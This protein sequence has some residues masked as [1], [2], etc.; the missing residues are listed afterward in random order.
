MTNTTRETNIERSDPSLMYL[1][2]MLFSFHNVPLEKT[3]RKLNAGKHMTTNGNWP[4]MS[5]E[6]WLGPE[7]KQTECD[8]F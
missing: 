5:I 4:G 3:T 6:S 8:Y 2:K 7:K 1:N